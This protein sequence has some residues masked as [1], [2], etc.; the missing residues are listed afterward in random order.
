LKLLIDNNLSFK[1]AHSLQPLFPEHEITPLREK[2]PA[3]TPDVEWIQAL[4]AEGGWAA[5]TAERK[6]KTRPHERLALERSNVVFFFLTG[7]WLKCSVADQAWRL[8]RLV[9]AMAAQAGLAEGLF[10]LPV[11]ATSKLRQHGR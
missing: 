2:F 4:D 6:L 5:L 9:P 1:L 8:I 11:N 10:D 7:H 3:N